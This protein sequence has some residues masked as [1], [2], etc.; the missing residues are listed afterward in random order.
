MTTQEYTSELQRLKKEKQDLGQ[1]FIE[2][3]SFSELTGKLVK[4]T[5]GFSTKKV[6]FAGVGIQP[7]SLKSTS[8]EPCLF[9]HQLKKDG[10]PNKRL[11]YIPVQYYDGKIYKFE[12]ISPK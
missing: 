6:L 7:A 12:K 8:G 1:R 9:Y 3:N 2:D 4:L 11:E 10:T 5:I